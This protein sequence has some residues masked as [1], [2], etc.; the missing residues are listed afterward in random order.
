MVQRGAHGKAP[1][2]L[3]SRLPSAS[4][5]CDWRLLLLCDC[6]GDCWTRGMGDSHKVVTCD[7]TLIIAVSRV[8]AEVA[9]IWRPPYD[10][11]EICPNCSNFIK[12]NLFI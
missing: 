11:D 6:E 7:L 2:A 8:L 1:L 5:G 12:N 4:V 3:V 9:Y 10:E